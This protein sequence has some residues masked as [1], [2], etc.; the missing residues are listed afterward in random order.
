MPKQNLTRRK[1]G[2][3][4]LTSL[5]PSSGYLLTM[6][7]DQTPPKSRRASQLMH[8]V[9]VAIRAIEQDGEVNDLEERLEN[10]GHKVKAVST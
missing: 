8:S 5:S 4:S 3:N 1:Q 7:P 6:S 9:E 10:N 2:V